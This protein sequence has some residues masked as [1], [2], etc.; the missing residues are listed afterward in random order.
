MTG[1]ISL[2]PFVYQLPPN[3]QYLRDCAPEKVAPGMGKQH[4]G[5]HERY[6]RELLEMRRHSN[7]VRE[8][9]R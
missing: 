3:C 1:K 7:Y 2:V 9:L 4:H 6:P 5:D 8:S